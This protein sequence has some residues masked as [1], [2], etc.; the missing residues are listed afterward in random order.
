LQNSKRLPVFLFVL[1]LPS[2][3]IWTSI[4]GKEALIC[5]ILLLIFKIWNFSEKLSW[6]NKL[7]LAISSLFILFYKPHY[8][9]GFIGFVVFQ[10]KKL[11]PLFRQL[12]YFSIVILIL[13][14]YDRISL[15]IE[16]LNALSVE[17]PRHFADSNSGTRTDF[18]FQADTDWIYNIPFGTLIAFWGPTF[19]EA[20]HSVKYFVTF[21][22]SFIIFFFICGQFYRIVSV[23]G[24]VVRH[25]LFITVLTVVLLFL[26]ANYPFGFFNPGSALRYRSAYLP[27][28]F[29]FLELMYLR[30]QSRKVKA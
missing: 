22:E 14:N 1:L 18:F 19:S 15:F 3:S 21:F 12:I 30:T 29:F 4:P 24:F 13:L 17:L 8:I 7:M 9:A 2:I 20:I 25:K 16:T 10:I 28:I 27:F 11:K 6:I 5:F 23:R 26:I